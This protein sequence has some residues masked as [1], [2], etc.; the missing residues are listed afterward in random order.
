M[1]AG[2]ATWTG[3]FSPVNASVCKLLLWK[4]F[5]LCPFSLNF[6]Q[7]ESQVRQIFCGLCSDSGLLWTTH[8]CLWCWLYKE[9]NFDTE[10]LSFNF[11]STKNKHISVHGFHFTIKRVSFLTKP[12]CHLSLWLMTAAQNDIHV[13]NTEHSS[14]RQQSWDFRS[15][16][17]AQTEMRSWAHT[18][19]PLQMTF[20]LMIHQVWS[21]C[22]HDV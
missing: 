13:R 22:G 8:H 12:L 6:C 20:Q 16:C 9:L 1:T 5:L 17:L 2:M 3:L 11:A 10:D 19:A 14:D 15:A 18:S 4:S 7:T 21:M